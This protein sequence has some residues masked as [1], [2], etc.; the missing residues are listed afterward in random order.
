MAFNQYISHPAKIDNGDPTLLIGDRGR[1]D[2]D[3]H[4][5]T[6]A[7]RMKAACRRQTLTD[8]T[9]AKPVAKVVS[10]THDFAKLTSWAQKHLRDQPFQQSD[11]YRYHAFPSALVT[12]YC[13]LECRD[14][15]SDHAV[16]VATLVVA[17]HHNIKSPPD[18]SKMAERYGRIKE[19]VQGTYERVRSQF[20]DIDDEVPDRADRIIRA[21]TEGEGSWGEFREWH[22]RR[23]EPIDGAHDHLV[24]FA[25]MRDGR[26][27]DGYYTDV[28]RLWTALKFADQ[29]A[30]SGLENDD[31]D[32]TLPGK[33]NLDDH[34]AD[35]NDG[36]GV[37]ADLNRLRD[38][39]RKDA[40]A[41]VEALVQSGDVG[42]ITLPT[43]FGKTYAGLSAGLQAA[44]ISD[45]R[46]V[47]VLPYTSILDQTAKEIQTVFG[48]SPYSKAFTLH[49]HLSNTYTGLSDHHTDA[50]IGRSPGALHAESWLS[51]L[52]LT[53]TVQLFES[54]AAPTARQATRVPSLH[55]A[56]VVLDEPQAIPETW[57][58]IVPALVE[59]LVAT[60]DAT[61]ILMT[62]TQPGL[63]KYG[64]DVLDTRELIDD[65]DQ[66]TDF[67]A[68]NPRVTYRLHDTVQAE[69]GDGAA[70]L[71]YS[72]AGARVTEAANGGKDVL[73]ICNTRASA[74]ELYQ[75]VTPITEVG[76]DA[77]VELGCLL[78][79]YTAETGKL[80]SLFQLRQFVLTAAS[81]KDAE[82]VYAFLS[83][84]VRPDDRSLI[85]DA[86]YDDEAGDPDDPAPLLDSELSVV[87]VS[88]S[89]V[90]A[91]VDISFDTVFRDYAPIPNLVQSGGRCNRSFGGETG[92]VIVWRLA[93][94]EDGNSIP[95][96]VIHGG[97]GGNALPLLRETGRVLRRHATEDGTITE[98][99]M[100]S[101]TV[102]DFYESLFEGP[103]D[104]GD[105]QLA[106][107]VDSVSMSELAGEHMI[108][109]IKDYE[110][111]V[112]CLTHKEQD[113]LL[114]DDMDVADIRRH[115]GAQ[116]NTDPETWTDELIIGISR[117]LVLDARDAP[118]HPVFGVR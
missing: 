30:A 11:E 71:N 45:S 116:V 52:T 91:G 60:Y 81:D 83:G 93:E 109:D 94:P 107:A 80:P 47:Y 101:D 5:R 42:L 2:D 70:T 78:H 102:S 25:E 13:L 110:D 19:G 40:T 32:G 27:R 8:G 56:V 18:P 65:A 16:E 86:I 100:V 46:L 29:T 88:T 1:F 3:G 22:D 38:L 37:L 111:V 9:P 35:L 115:P 53:T 118:Y 97:D 90:E 39:A 17:G 50:D 34:I 55:E 12:L 74:K 24:Y 54:L 68:D 43:G 28:I 76:K 26:A 62:A 72:K 51:G 66:Y 95:S 64:S 87:L 31:I 75:H 59:I 85:I 73:A 33:G 67:L 57:W 63:V 21:A 20:D 117:Y 89:V 103:L 10:L 6:V 48:V 92:D 7:D 96:L 15:V 84:D 104:P 69:M 82:T 79:E 41:N 114:T 44:D 23:T 113:D 99:M 98:S 4:L 112:A 61:I 14:Q 105:E 49:H 108:D 36:E 106:A 77:P 58:Q